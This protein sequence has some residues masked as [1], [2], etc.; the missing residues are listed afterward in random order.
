MKK[1]SAAVLLSLIISSATGSEAKLDAPTYQRSIYSI[2]AVLDTASKTLSGAEVIDYYYP[3]ESQTAEIVLHL[4]PNAF[5]DTTTLMARGDADIGAK[6]AAAPGFIDCDSIRINGQPPDSISIRETL[7][8][9]YPPR[10]I[11]PA[12]KAIIELNFRLRIP[13][14][15]LRYGHDGHGNYLLAHWYPILAGFQKGRQIVFDYGPHTEFF[16]N[17]SDYKINL[18]LPANFSVAS[19]AGTGEPDS[20]VEGYSF[21][22]LSSE[23]VIDFAFGCGPAWMTQTTR[24]N[25]IN[26]DIFYLPERRDMLPE[27]ERTIAATLD[28]F[29]SRFFTYP[30]TTLTFIDFNPGSGGMELP[31]MAAMSFGD[32][33][34]AVKSEALFA[35]IHET[36]HQWFYAVIATNEADEAWLDEGLTTYLTDKAAMYVLGQANAIDFLGIKLSMADMRPLMVRFLG[37]LDPLMT[38]GENF[39]N[40]NYSTN[41]YGRAPAVINTLE[42]ILGTEAFEAALG[43]F[44]VRYKFG[45]PDSRDFMNSLEHSAGRELDRFFDMYIYGTARVDYEVA[46]LNSERLTNRNDTDSIRQDK[47]ETIVEVRRGYDGV[48]P[49]EI[50]VCF[51]DGSKNTQHWDGQASYREFRSYSATPAVWAAIDTA[52][53]YLIDENLANNSLKATPATQQLF[54]FCG[55]LGFLAQFLLAIGGML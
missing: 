38:S 51:E 40:D 7:L 4:Y 45:H 36:G 24:H 50:V 39:H 35:A 6:I 18:T 20:S 15:I 22:S 49:Q 43:E 21:Y 1:I 17:F 46:S 32:R 47:Y 2:T 23:N 10:P 34:N 11:E 13:P 19:T 42:G 14:T 9:I 33:R 54:S 30:Y 44:A 52:Y 37:S 5:R 16:S 55:S 12:S 48:L 53:F 27:F 28:Y 41:I 31:A 25:D 29:G 3:G 26:I 8:Y